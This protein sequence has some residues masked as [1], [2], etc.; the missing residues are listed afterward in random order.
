MATP[1]PDFELKPHTETFNG[2]ILDMVARGCTNCCLDRDRPGLALWL[3]AFSGTIGEQ[4]RGGFPTHVVT[5][6]FVAMRA[7]FDTPEAADC[8]IAKYTENTNYGPEAK[9]PLRFARLSP[10]VLEIAVIQPDHGVMTRALVTSGKM[11]SIHPRDAEDPKDH[12]L[13]SLLNWL[14]GDS[15]R[16]SPSDPEIGVS[17]LTLCGR[18]MDTEPRKKLLNGESVPTWEI[19][20]VPIELCGRRWNLLGKSCFAGGWTIPNICQFVVSADP[21]HHRRAL[22]CP[23]NG[24]VLSLTPELAGLEMQM[25]R[26]IR[27]SLR[28]KDLAF[29]RRN[30]IHG[31]PM[32]GCPRRVD[33]TDTYF[34]QRQRSSLYNIAARA[35]VDQ[36]EEEVDWSEATALPRHVR[37]KLTATAPTKKSW[38]RFRR[39]ADFGSEMPLE[40][41][42]EIDD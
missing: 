7:E 15:R 21:A 13:V 25:N 17:E 37:N 26:L 18:I 14:S 22:D 23:P 19:Q 3:T 16:R 35:V 20:E 28:D 11:W 10:T 32:W 2:A 34:L 27:W 1:A 4:K 30:G 5:E 29:L 40:Y 31:I 24:S 9:E 36:Q 42:V 8:A 41:T 12:P 39:G 6:G 38:H 33:Q